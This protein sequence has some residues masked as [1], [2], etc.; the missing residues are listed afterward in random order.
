VHYDICYCSSNSW[1]HFI[2][3]PPPSD[4]ICHGTPRNSHCGS[5]QTGRPIEGEGV[6]EST[7]LLRA[8]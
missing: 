3:P 6:R 1:P 8:P 5:E 4:S 7:N 2:H